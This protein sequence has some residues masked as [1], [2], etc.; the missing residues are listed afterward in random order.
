MGTS[1]REAQRR[2]E[3]DEFGE[4]IAYWTIKAEIE[5]AVEPEPTPDE[6]GDKIAAWAAMHN[7]R[8]G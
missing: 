8:Q 5:G 6:L 3:G 1:V 4:W 7:A 2:V